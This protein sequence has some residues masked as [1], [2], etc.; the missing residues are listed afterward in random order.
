MST[1]LDPTVPRPDI[2]SRYRGFRPGPRVGERVPAGWVSEPSTRFELSPI[3]PQIGAVVDGV[4]L[5]DPVDDELF[6]QLNRAL[7]EWKV[8]VFRNQDIT[9]DQQAGF[10]RRWGA[11][12]SHPFFKLVHAENDDI[13]PEIVRLAKDDKT[14]GY[15]NT[16]HSDVSWRLVPSLGSILRAI[17]VPDVGGDTMW[18]DM[19]AAYD[20]LSDDMKQRIDGLV[21][22]HDWIDSFGRGMSEQERAEL[23]PDF[24]AVEHPVVRT[25]PETGRKTIYVNRNFTQHIVGL[26]PA[27]SED[28]IDFLCLQATIPE[29][30]CRWRWQPGDVVF[31][32][33]RS[34][35]HYAV[36]D[37][38]P[39][40]RVMERITVIGDQPF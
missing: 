4:S 3:A 1:A 10:A 15:E 5:A 19:G 12:E 40:R 28:L 39:S 24:P 7:L 32:D 16:W 2:P 25:H 13:E 31:W 11:L 33:N 26:D 20:H 8:L 38:Y 18:A 22:V 17:E 6:Q 36:S 29:Y 30:Q 35:Q 34:T 37:Y 14:G 21:A 23:R 9:G 27:E